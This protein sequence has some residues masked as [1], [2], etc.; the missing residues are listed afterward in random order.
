MLSSTAFPIPPARGLLFAARGTGP[1]P[2]HGSGLRPTRAAPTLHRLLHCLC[3]SFQEKGCRSRL[4][5]S[6]SSL[7]ALHLLFATTH[8]YKDLVST[9]VL[10]YLPTT[11]HQKED[12]GKQPFPHTFFF[13]FLL[14]LL[15][16]DCKRSV[17]D[18]ILS[19]V[20]FC[21]A[22]YL[23]Q[24]SSPISSAETKCHETSEFC[25]S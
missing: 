21:L 7:F 1:D 22:L 13:F 16:W 10:L 23:F 3:Q 12:K 25:L 9:A 19:C 17:W 14:L 4:P 5:F 11:G 24:V 18:L 6:K 2:H 15:L 20:M 8:I